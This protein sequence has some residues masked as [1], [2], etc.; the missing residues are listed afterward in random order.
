[1]DDGI[2]GRLV[3]LRDAA[4]QEIEGV[5]GQRVEDVV[6]GHDILL[7]PMRRAL[8]HE[9][10]GRGHRSRQLALAHLGFA[11]GEGE[12][13]VR[14]NDI[15]VSLMRRALDHEAAGRVHRSRQ[16][17]FAHLGFADGEGAVAALASCTELR[18]GGWARMTRLAG[19]RARICRT[20]VVRSLSAEISSA[21]SKWLSKASVSSCMAMLTSVIF[22]S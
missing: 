1:M 7:S 11:D 19:N 17:A 10:A 18:P 13:L 12:D 21:A 5:A 9:A 3:E 16:L 8:D 4:F 15:L 14:C 22:S 20:G 2:L 6:M